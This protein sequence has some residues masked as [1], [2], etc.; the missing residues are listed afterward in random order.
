LAEQILIVDKESDT[1]ETVRT[2]LEK[3]GFRVISTKDAEI[4]LDIIQH[5][6]PDLILLDPILRGMDGFS[7]CKHLKREHQTQHVPICMI[8]AQDDEINRVLAFELGV[9]DYLKKPFSLRELLLRIRIILKRKQNTPSKDRLTYGIL[10]I[11]KLGLEAFLKDTP[12]PLTVIEF[13]LLVTLLERIGRVQTREDLLNAVWG[14]EH[15]GNGRMV[16]AHIKRMRAKLGDAQSMIRTVRS[17]GYC[18]TP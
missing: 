6:L 11:D 2:H 12:I 7:F 17:I 15:S 5:E 18:F 10:S 8:S 13:Q 3:T 14:Y 4:A 16:D 9:D 1:V